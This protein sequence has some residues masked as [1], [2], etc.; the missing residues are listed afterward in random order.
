M[1]MKLDMT[2]PELAEKAGTGLRI[3]SVIKAYMESNDPKATERTTIP[4]SIP[5]VA[6]LLYRP[7][8]I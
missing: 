7:S 4:I 3:I 8:Y 1:A 2:Q 6:N 5:L